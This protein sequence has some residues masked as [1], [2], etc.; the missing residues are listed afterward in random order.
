MID[1]REWRRLD[2]DVQAECACPSL[3][4]EKFVIR[5][6]NINEQGLCCAVPTTLKPGQKVSLGVDLKA[7]GKAFLNTK[8]VWSGYFEKINEYRAG[9]KIIDTEKEEYEAFLRFY[10]FQALK[11]HKAL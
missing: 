1:K 11:E 9:F 3:P 6:L 2:V 4:T 8:V 10:N 7:H 5:V